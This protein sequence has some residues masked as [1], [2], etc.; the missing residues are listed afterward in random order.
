M[1]WVET[2]GD[3]DLKTSLRTLDRTDFFTREL[4]QL[5]LQNKIR[6][7]IHSAKDLPEPLPEGLAIAALTRGV[8][9]RDALVLRSGETLA[10]LPPCAVIA[11]S[12][13]RREEVVRQLRPDLRFIDLRGTIGA[14][15]AKLETGEADGIVVAEAALIRLR[16]THLNRIFLPGP[17]APLQG[18]LALV[19][20]KDDVELQN[21]LS[22]VHYEDALSR[23]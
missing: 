18:R 4:D 11:T 20:R 10:T 21:L 12:S 8:D 13:A 16:L 23:P 9:A 15:L 22:A 5:L 3:R 19:V 2:V 17:T 14:R 6:L 1:T 7:A